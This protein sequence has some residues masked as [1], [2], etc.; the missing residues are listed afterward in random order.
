[1][2]S[3]NVQPSIT[4]FPDIFSIALLDTMATLSFFTETF[5]L[6][7]CASVITAGILSPSHLQFLLL[8]G[9]VKSLCAFAL[10]FSVFPRPFA[11]HICSFSR[12]F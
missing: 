11:F 8:H 7:P 1:M 4:N 2:Y 3:M 12:I 9:H 10:D 5:H 6:P